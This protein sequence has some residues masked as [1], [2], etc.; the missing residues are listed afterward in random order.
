MHVVL[1]SRGVKWCTIRNSWCRF[2]DSDRL[3]Q[4]P[5]R[6]MLLKVQKL[7]RVMVVQMN[8]EGGID[9]RISWS[10]TQKSEILQNLT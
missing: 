2:C 5:C 10:E 1:N 6:V 9:R 4:S 3:E 8:M 7:D